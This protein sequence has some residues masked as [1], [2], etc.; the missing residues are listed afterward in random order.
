MMNALVA[1]ANSEFELRNG[2]RLAEQVIP[3]W[4]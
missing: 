1:V 3:D 2:F 4:S